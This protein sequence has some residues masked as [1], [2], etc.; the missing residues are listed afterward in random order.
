MATIPVEEEVTPFTIDQFLGLNISKTGDTQ[1]LNGESGNMDNFYITNDYKLKKMYGY[2]TIYNFNSRIRG[3]FKCNI[4]STNYMLIAANG[5]LYKISE[6]E[7]EDASNTI[8]PTQI[9][10]IDDDSTSFF[11]F[12]KKIYVLTGHEYKVWDGTTLKDV[13]GYIPKVYISTTPAGSGT[14]FDQIN[15]LTG[16]KHQTFNGDGESKTYH[17]AEKT[18]CL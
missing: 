14:P 15:L 12:D 2:K 9:G 10:E 11:L 16:K 6:L 8:V 5:Y 3:L 1:I 7:L 17:L 4:N 13:E 18:S